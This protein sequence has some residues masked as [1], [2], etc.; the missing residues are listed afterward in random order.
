MPHFSTVRGSASGGL[1]S[2][3]AQYGIMVAVSMSIKGIWTKYWSLDPDS[4]DTR[5]IS[6]EFFSD[7][8]RT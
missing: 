4:A 7:A 3:V 8:S 2:Y 1:G 5:Y 6:V